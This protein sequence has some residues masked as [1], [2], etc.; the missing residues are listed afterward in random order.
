VGGG[1]GER[2]G[3]IARRSLLRPGNSK[4]IPLLPGQRFYEFE[5]QA[6]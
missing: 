2:E 4:R 5:E 1:E 3:K 6:T